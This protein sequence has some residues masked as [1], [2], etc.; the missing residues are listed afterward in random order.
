MSCVLTC[1]R[2]ILSPLAQQVLVAG[3]LVKIDMGVH[4]DGYIT[5]SAHTAIVG[6]AAGAAGAEPVTGPVADVFHAAYTCAEVAARMITP[7]ATNTDVTEA[8]KRVCATFGVH[9]LQ[10]SIMH[11]VKRYVIDGNKNIAM[12]DP[13]AD[14]GK[15]DKCT[16]EAGEI[17]ALDICL[18]T[19]EGKRKEKN[20]RTTVYRRVVDTKYGLKI[21]SSRKFLNEV[22][23]KFP[24]LPFTLRQVS[25]FGLCMFSAVSCVLYC[26]YVVS[27]APHASTHSN[28]H[29]PSSPV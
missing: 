22:N 2:P 5:V 7:G 23:T 20:T 11:Q 18:S 28:L 3:D 16:F 17:Y 12:H 26:M 19:A 15:T 29:S 10:G 24:S 25:S 27:F 9:P 4:I 21:A 6:H 13:T 8:M 1:P 14:T